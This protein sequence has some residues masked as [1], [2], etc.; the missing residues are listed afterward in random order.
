[1]MTYLMRNSYSIHVGVPSSWE[2]KPFSTDW[3]L[4]NIWTCCHLC[5]VKGR[6]GVYY[7]RKS[8]Q[9]N[10]FIWRVSF[11][12]LFAWQTFHCLMWLHGSSTVLSTITSQIPKISFLS[13]SIK[14]PTYN[15][16]PILLFKFQRK[17]C[18]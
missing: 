15:Y 3:K 2:H 9:C 11:G 7:N 18:C 12:V 8:A 5:V 14:G 6:Y 17:I 10:A 1:M 13:T 16:L 4:K